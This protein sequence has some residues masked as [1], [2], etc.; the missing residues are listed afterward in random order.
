MGETCNCGR[1]GEFWERIEN[2]RKEE[3]VR[4]N[5]IVRETTAGEKECGRK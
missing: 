5:R 2:F 1:D 3:I 4:E